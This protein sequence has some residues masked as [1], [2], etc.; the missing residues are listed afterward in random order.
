MSPSSF[1]PLF[2]AL[3]VFSFAAVPSSAEIWTVTEATDPPLPYGVH[4]LPVSEGG[5]LPAA[6][7]CYLRQAMQLAADGDSI[8]FSPSVVAAGSAVVSQGDLAFSD[9]RALT[10][11][12]D[13]PDLFAIDAG[14]ASRVFD[15]SGGSWLT[16]EGI[17]LRNGNGSGGHGG[18]ARA[19][20]TGTVLTLTDC[21]IEN[22]TGGNG[23]GLRVE[24]GATATLTQCDVYRNSAG[25]GGGIA[26]GDNGTL[27]TL[28][29]TVVRENATSFSGGGIYLVNG[30]LVVQDS[31]LEDNCAG[32]ALAACP[33]TP[34]GGQDG[35][36]IYM[37]GGSG[38]VEISG[39][40]LVGNTAK[41]GGALIASVGNTVSIWNSTV[42]G[43]SAMSASG[44]G[45]SSSG[46]LLEL[47]NVTVAD[48][49]ASAG[50]GGIRVGSAATV[51]LLKNSLV[52]GNTG[53][54]S[55]DCGGETALVSGDYNVIGDMA[56]CNV[57]SGPGDQLG[58][59]V[60][61]PALSNEGGPLLPHG[62]PPLVHAIDAASP[63]FNAGHPGGCTNSEGNVVLTLDQTDT[64]RVQG[65][66]CDAGAYEFPVVP[67]CSDG[68][69]ND[70]D[71]LMDWDGGGVGAPD[72]GCGGDP[73][74]PT[75]S[76]ECD[77]GVDNDGDG[78][79]DSVD[80]DCLTSAGVSE[81]P[82][83]PTGDIM[84]TN[85]RDSGSGSFRAAIAAAAADPLDEYE[86]VAFEPWVTG[87]VR[88]GATINVEG[89]GKIVE[90]RGPGADVLT[91][92]A[93]GSGRIFDV[94]T[95]AQLTASGLT[96]RNG[97]GAGG[98]G[99]A[100]RARS[101]GTILDL[102]DCVIRDNTGNNGG[103]LRVESGA[104]ATL[105]QCDVY[106]NSAGSGGGIAIGDNGTLVTLIETVVRENASSATGGGIYLVNATLK[107]EDSNILDNCAGTALAACPGTPGGGADGGGLQVD[108][109]TA[110]V[111]ISGS[112]FVGNSARNGG[113]VF[114]AVNNT[115]R[116]SNTTVSRNRAVTGSGG[117][118]SS[119]GTM[120]LANVT[121]AHNTAGFGDGGLRIGNPSEV[122]SMK[123]SLI[124]ENT[125]GGTPDCGG[126]TSFVSEGYNLIGDGT[127]C[128]LTPDEN[129]CPSTDLVG[130][131]CG[132]PLP[133]DPDL[134]N[135]VTDNGGP[136]LSYYLSSLS[137][138]HDAGNPAGCTEIGAAGDLGADQRGRPR[139]VGDGCDIGAYETS[140]LW[141][142]AIEGHANSLVVD[143]ADNVIAVGRQSNPA[144]YAV[145]KLSSTGDVI[146]EP[147][148]LN[149][150]DALSVA[151][152]SGGNV[153]STGYADPIAYTSIDFLIEKRHA[154]DPLQDWQSMFRGTAVC[155]N[156]D[157]CYQCTLCAV[158]PYECGNGVV[159]AG[160]ACDGFAGC[161]AGDVCASDCSFCEPITLAT[162]GNGVL[163]AGLGETCDPSAPGASNGLVGPIDLWDVASS[164]ATDQSDNVLVAGV[165][166]NGGTYS[167][168]GVL[169]LDPLGSLLWR[170][171]F[172]GGVNWWSDVGMAVAADAQGDVFAAGRLA[173]QLSVLKLAG[174]DG[175]LLAMSSDYNADSGE[176]RSLVFDPSG[177]VVVAGNMNF[178]TG[179][180]DEFYITRLSAADLG[181]VWI[182]QLNGAPGTPFHDEAHDVAVDAA[183]DVI[184]VGSLRDSSNNAFFALVKIS[185]S[186]P[187]AER[188]RRLIGE[189]SGD[190]AAVEV[191]SSGDAAAAGQIAGM[192]SAAKLAGADGTTL[193]RESIGLGTANAVAIDSAGDIL[194][195][196]DLDDQFVVVKFSGDPD[197]TPDCSDG[198]DNDGDG[199][200][201]TA[202]GMCTDGS[203]PGD[204]GCDSADDES[205]RS[206][207]RPCDDGADNDGDGRSDFDPATFANPAQGVGD[208]GC[209]RPTWTL[210]N[211]ACQDGLNNDSAGGF[212]FD[213][214]ASLDL[215]SDGFVDAQFN[216]A[217][218]A[219][220]AA[221][222]DCVGKAWRNSELPPFRRCGLGFELALLLPGLMWL[223]R[224]M[225]AHG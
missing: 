167:D 172:D 134:P 97:N 129:T 178:G 4:C 73:L 40:S 158:A 124:A 91:L 62:S 93:G 75:E 108:A 130:G 217:T 79:L 28:I 80:P 195:A 159:D 92:D 18:A 48:N 11:R 131:A 43:N 46:L 219:V 34:G 68:I 204:P 206:D 203:T 54:G 67:E 120:Q 110:Q 197:P 152:D 119:V 89:A 117:G 201:D 5:M 8:E 169:K 51:V 33:G 151:V 13:G 61:L 221:D 177:D 184:A 200:C 49:T 196:G 14:N 27:V 145:V 2:R 135:E 20:E 208:P 66:A 211:P 15:V 64:A 144:D 24:S 52:A 222:P 133:I 215:D 164:V 42:S 35:G 37:D 86:S 138:A 101:S 156:A 146:W 60:G 95:G 121:V 44:G 136:S 189:S 170:K 165:F 205:E 7:A 202:S 17:T 181:P 171:D 213:G 83:P 162:C 102:A 16:V 127:G 38:E 199:R 187:Y 185:G 225:G 53:G 103:G 163:D 45:L 96:L 84:V 182:H 137:P 82:A 72:P 160:E 12:A 190:W 105:T 139:P 180:G 59:P 78:P 161:G 216:A 55:P 115:V 22:N 188:W 1:H 209:L 125:G 98:H 65:V 19:R 9:G 70:G 153:V 192:F 100:V 193:W 220:G 126:E 10:I 71:G 132:Q 218:P 157:A 39:S 85:N 191:D 140:E 29:E 207:S 118:L 99:G 141:R 166:E 128:N 223:R 77:D 32:T 149:F 174:V 109:G 90:I 148:S 3:I 198:I 123:N 26:I 76:P 31:S 114:S 150:G 173:D 175:G 74:A 194:V 63:A 58:V 87:P 147:L 142:Y 155:P 6:T 154:A 111:D 36:G 104:T 25:S 212:D 179:R 30:K 214:G 183:G 88:L 210:E 186:F 168:L 56:G 224:R 94:A 122:F 116:I 50:E 113:G 107:I 106:R 57:I 81:R 69:H 112:A 21:V 47:A 23:G 41:A 143:S 176:A